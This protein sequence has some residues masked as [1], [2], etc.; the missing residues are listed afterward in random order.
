MSE[1]LEVQKILKHEFPEGSSIVKTIEIMRVLSK[2]LFTWNDLRTNVTARWIEV[3][4]GEVKRGYCEDYPTLNVRYWIDDKDGKR[5]QED[6]NTYSC[7]TKFSAF[8]MNQ[9]IS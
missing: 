1:K 6:I 8:E 5:L 9:W 2:A 3:E 4:G 7:W